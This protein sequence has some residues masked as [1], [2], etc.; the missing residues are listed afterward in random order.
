MTSNSWYEAEKEAKEHS[1]FEKL[2]PKEQ[3]EMIE[4]IFKEKI[5]NLS[6][7]LVDC[8]NTMGNEK[9]VLN[10]MLDGIQ[11]S[12]RHLQQVFWNSM[13]NVMEQYSKTDQ[14][15]GRNSFAVEMC[16]RMSEVAY[17]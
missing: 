2:E 14:F 7:E 9:L 1:C 3:K 11:R 6:R 16:K 13:V 5:F 4:K 17:K 12:H 10:S 8:F 15:D